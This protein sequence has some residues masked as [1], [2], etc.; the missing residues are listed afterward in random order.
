MIIVTIVSID[1]CILMSQT[2]QTHLVGFP[3]GLTLITT[4]QCTAVTIQPH[5]THIVDSLD[6]NCCQSGQIVQ[7]NSGFVFKG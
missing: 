2:T 3:M 7:N 5:M 1:I 4:K 6:L